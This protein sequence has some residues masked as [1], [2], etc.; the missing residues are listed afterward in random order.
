MIN[1]LIIITIFG[2]LVY[3]LFN[4][5]NKQFNLPPQA[6]TT[7]VFRTDVNEKYNDIFLEPYGCFK[8][9]NE[10]F[11]KK[12]LKNNLI[13]SGM[14][15][16]ENNIDVN[17]L[18][19]QVIEN[20]FDIYGYSM[21]HK[22][23]GDYKSMNIVELGI[24]G[25]LIGYNYLSVYKLSEKSRGTVYLT[26]S[27]PMDNDLEINPSKQDFPEYTL[28]PLLNK[29]TNEKEEDTEK[30]LSCGYPCLSDGVEPLVLNGK[31]YMCGSDGYP[32]IKTLTRVAVYRISE[33]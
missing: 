1:L 4:L 28:T 29:Y 22:Y 12:Q 23:N 6:A 33:K 27:P 5:I 21:I 8:S 15:I 20:G 11:F 24:L 26:Y 19:K 7:K 17:N 31:H 9:I 18:I 13:D 10:K 30:E 14:M 32:D 2:L 3:Y 25:K 16:S